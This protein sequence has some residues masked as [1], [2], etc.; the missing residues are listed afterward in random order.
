MGAFLNVDDWDFPLFGPHL[1][2][3]VEPLTLSARPRDY[4]ADPASLRFILTDRAEPEVATLFHD[5]RLVGCRVTWAID[6]ADTVPWRL[7]ACQ[8][9]HAPEQRLRHVQAS[10]DLYPVA[11][12]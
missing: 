1:D 7:Y 12:K 11:Y 6:P 2:R 9:Q 3:T 4:R 8:Q 5:M 10:R